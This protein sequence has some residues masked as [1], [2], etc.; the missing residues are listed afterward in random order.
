M[1]PLSDTTKKKFTR[2]HLTSP[3][4]TR[5]YRHSPEFTGIALLFQGSCINIR[6][7]SFL[8]TLPGWWKSAKLHVSESASI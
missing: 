8:C 1:R 2:L 3:D 4:F 5:V 6:S 7:V